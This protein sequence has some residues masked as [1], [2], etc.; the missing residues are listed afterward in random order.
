[1]CS[2]IVHAWLQI[3]ER[4]DQL[5]GEEKWYPIFEIGRRRGR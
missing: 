5:D 2:V 3:E 4:I 1:V